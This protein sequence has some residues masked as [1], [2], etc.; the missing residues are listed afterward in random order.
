MANYTDETTGIK[1]GT[2]GF[3]PNAS[4]PN[5]IPATE[6]FTFGMALPGDALDKDASEYIGLLVGW[7]GQ[8][9]VLKDL[10]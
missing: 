4:D 5:S 3:L 2:W 1:F 10:D 9:P 7:D 8:K 6:A